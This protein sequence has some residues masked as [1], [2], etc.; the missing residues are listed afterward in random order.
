MA[1]CQARNIPREA[2]TLVGVLF[3]GWLAPLEALSYGRA[4]QFGA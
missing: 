4:G 3:A 2:G 1:S